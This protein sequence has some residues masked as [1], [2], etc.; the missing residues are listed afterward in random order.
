[1]A[2]LRLQRDI[3][4]GISHEIRHRTDRTLDFLLPGYS[5][6][7][8]RKLGQVFPIGFDHDGFRLQDMVFCD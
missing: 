5:G 8:N 6:T 2:M 3:A 1:M 4:V 7:V